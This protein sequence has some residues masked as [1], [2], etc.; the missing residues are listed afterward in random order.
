MMVH[1]RM[2][3]VLSLAVFLSLP[4]ASEMSAQ[5]RRAP[6]GF[7]V[8]QLFPEMAFPALEAGQRVSLADFRGKKT[9]L[10]IFASW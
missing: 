1:Y 6:G 3:A 5:S 4:W 7:E 9:L 10:H 8:G 2:P